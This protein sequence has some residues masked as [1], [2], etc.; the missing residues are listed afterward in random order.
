MNFLKL[1][2]IPVWAAIQPGSLSES[3]H[4]SCIGCHLEESPKRYA[5]DDGTVKCGGC[6]LR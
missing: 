1:K 6:H 2:I 3:Y 4:A 5:N